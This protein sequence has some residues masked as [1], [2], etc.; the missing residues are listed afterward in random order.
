MRIIK[1]GAGV[2]EI[3]MMTE[4]YWR[5]DM[6]FKE[7]KTLPTYRLDGGHDLKIYVAP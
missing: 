4:I 1:D 5:V 3:D 7:M 2:F 6:S